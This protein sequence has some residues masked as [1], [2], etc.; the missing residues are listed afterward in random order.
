MNWKFWTKKSPDGE[1]QNQEEK[2]PKPKDLPSQLGQHLV[3]KLN[4]DPNWVWS[5]KCALRPKKGFKNAFEFIIFDNLK[6]A[7][8]GVRIQNYHSFQEHPEFILYE[9]R[10][11]KNTGL[12]VLE[13][14]ESQ[15]DMGQAA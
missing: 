13:E 2:L 15:K 5:L 1:N 8:A 3:I 11:D 7:E 14:R 9:G 12:I 6:T 4:K 10:F